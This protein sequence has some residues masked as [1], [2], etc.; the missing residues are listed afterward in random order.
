[1]PYPCHCGTTQQGEGW[2]VLTRS[3]VTMTGQLLFYWCEIEHRASDEIAIV[4][5][6]LGDATDKDN[7]VI[8]TTKRTRRPISTIPTL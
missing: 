5:T 1:M 3:T 7:H 8:A 2:K 4:Q 6:G